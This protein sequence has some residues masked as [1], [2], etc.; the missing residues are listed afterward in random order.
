MKQMWMFF[1][2]FFS[3]VCMTAN[4]QTFGIK[5]NIPY[6]GTLTPNIGIEVALGKKTTF[7]VI[8]GINPFTLSDYKYLKHWLIHTEYRYWTC[9]KFNGHFFGLHGLA[10]QY[11]V[12]G[13]DIPFWHLKNLKENRYQGYAYGGGISYGHQWLLNNRW[14]L[15]LT[16]GGGYV[17]F[18]YEKFPC[19]KCGSSQGKGDKDYFGPTKGAI[20]IIY[21]LK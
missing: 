4:S 6:W 14:N 2:C 8:G 10:A 17:R 20:S 12:G 16:L 5:T 21:I 7:E 18:Q 1:G 3:L 11:N 15:E 9:E 13:W 19:T